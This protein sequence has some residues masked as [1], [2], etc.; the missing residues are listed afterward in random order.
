MSKNKT[1]KYLSLIIALLAL[2]TFFFMFALAII[3]INDGINQLSSMNRGNG[4]RAY[5]IRIIVCDF[6]DA[7]LNFLIAIALVFACI[8][9]IIEYDT[10]ETVYNLHLTELAM[11]NLYVA[12]RVVVSIATADFEP[13]LTLKLELFGSLISVI[14]LVM[15]MIVIKNKYVYL[16]FIVIGGTFM[17]LTTS[18]QMINQSGITLVYVILELFYIILICAY[19]IANSVLCISEAEKK[20]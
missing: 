3:S 1:L 4:M 6:I 19:L 12:L 2:T 7:G 8:C 10:G 15:N 16:S 9:N 20:N 13:D 11:L 5:N 17:L 18:I 14:F